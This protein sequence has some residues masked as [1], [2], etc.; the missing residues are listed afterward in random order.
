MS[1]GAFALGQKVCAREQIT[2]DA[3]GGGCVHK[4]Q[5]VAEVVDFK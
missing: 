4:I 3:R 1:C 2:A 5:D